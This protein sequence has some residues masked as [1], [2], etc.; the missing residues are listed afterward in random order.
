MSE[1]GGALMAVLVLLVVII[2]AAAM[3][4]PPALRHTEQLEAERLEARLGQWAVGLRAFRRDFDRFP[5]AGEG[6]EVLRTD[7]GDPR[8]RGPYVDLGLDA[9][10]PWGEPLSYTLNGA[11]VTLSSTALGAASLSIT[12]GADEALRV[13]RAR[14]EMALIRI[15]ADRFRANGGALPTSMAQLAAGWLGGDYLVDPWGTSYILDGGSIRSASIDL[16]HGT[17]DD[18]SEALP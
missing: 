8:W 4:V 10:D 7:N 3:L 18:L 13:A 1:R 2:A 11:I 9:N 12:D 6:I 14:D 17:T 15:A 5:T 16:Q